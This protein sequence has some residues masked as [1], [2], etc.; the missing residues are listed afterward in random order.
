MTEEEAEGWIE[1]R[2]GPAAHARCREFVRLVRA[3]ATRQNL[4]A[5]STLEQIWSRHVVDSAQLVPLAPGEGMWLDIGTGAGFPGLVV[6]LLRAERTLVV[7][8][9]RLRGN[10]L[11][12]AA[13]ELDL[14][15]VEVHTAKV[16]SMATSA[17]VIS[18][19]AVA[20]VEKLLHAAASCATTATRW[21]LPRGRTGA[22]EL[23]QLRQHWTGEF[24]VEQSLTDPDSSVLVL[25][26][27]ASRRTSP[28]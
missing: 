24:H 11:R 22:A 28:R 14:S 16:E 2:F 6:A 23:A 5:P 8:P 21:L 10:F 15:S 17:A 18:A 20:P 26:H 19:R 9:R 27:V 25:D 3:E 1:D 12:A 4:I 7:E 13:A